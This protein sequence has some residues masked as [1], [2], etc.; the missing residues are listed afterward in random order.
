MERNPLV[1]SESPVRTLRTEESVTDLRTR[2]PLTRLPGRA[3]LLTELRQLA[4]PTLLVLADLDGLREVNARHGLPA[5]DKLLRDTAAQLSELVAPARLYRTGDGEFGWLQQPIPADPAGYAEQLQATWHTRA[6]HSPLSVGWVQADPGDGM[7]M[8]LARAAAAVGAG[9]STAGKTGGFT[10]LDEVAFSR[11][12]TVSHALSAAL[13]SDGRQLYLV[14]QPIRQLLDGELVAVETLV[15][16]EH[17]TLG[18][19][20]PD[21]FVTLAEQTGQSCELDRWVMTHALEEARDLPGHPRMHVNI[22]AKSLA[23]PGFTGQLLDLIGHSGIDPSQLCVELTETALASSGN[24]LQHALATLHADGIA[25]SIDDFGT[26]HASWS[27]L[28][29]LKVDEL[30]LDK[31]YVQGLPDHT[32]KLAVVQAILAV[33]LACGQQVVA[34]GVETPEQA[35][36]LLALGCRFGQGYL[37]GRPERHLGPTRT[38]PPPAIASGR[39]TRHRPALVTGETDG[40]QQLT[41][42]ARA[43]SL[44][45]ADPE[46]VFR[47]TMAV[48]RR[49][50]DFDGGS[51]QL[52]G[53]DGVRLVAAD[54]PPP[55]E[56]FSARLPVGQ[57]VAGTVL[58]TGRPVYLPDITASP[59]VPAGR[60]AISGGVR[61]YLA[62]PLFADGEAIGVLQVDSSHID[63]F[64]PQDRLQLAATAPLV[65]SALQQPTRLEAVPLPRPAQDT[66]PGH[67]H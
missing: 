28:S 50:I 60:R 48:L 21:E 25:I 55:P 65:A 47:L 3:A 29:D 12:E 43:L 46:A 67:P 52:V 11:R 37:L 51:L 18:V 9:K 54:P 63:A 61:S 38:L 30:K 16:W 32:D 10:A 49:S 24:R 41:D 62:V 56:A 5:G 35:Q 53:S 2:D 6:D 39:T 58:S 40:A 26:G 17:P 15:R 13:H 66:A 14:F 27:Y 59:A 19:I 44:A 45:P 34:E 1:A 20:T 42:L 23:T 31:S 7:G 36:A 64:N 8:A 33:A 4:E 22:S 57:G